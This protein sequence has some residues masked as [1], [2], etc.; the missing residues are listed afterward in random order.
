MPILLLTNINRLLNKLDELSV[1]VADLKLDFIALTETWL[2]SDIPDSA[3]SLSSYSIVRKD[4]NGQLGG[5]VM[6]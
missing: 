4:R 6:V 2:N 1:I 5:A 3:C